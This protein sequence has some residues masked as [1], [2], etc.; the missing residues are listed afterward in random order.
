MLNLRIGRIG[1]LFAPGY[2]SCGRCKTPWR[3]VKSH[4]THYAPGEWIFAL[5]RKCWAEL[6]P[7]ERLPF[8]QQVWNDWLAR[9]LDRRNWW[10]KIAFAVLNENRKYEVA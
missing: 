6:T 10:P 8:Y 7:E 1:Q 4:D 2:S 3:F 5:C 9:G